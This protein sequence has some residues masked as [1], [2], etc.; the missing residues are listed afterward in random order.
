MKS[1]VSVQQRPCESSS[2]LDRVGNV[3][4]NDVQQLWLGTE[5]LLTIRT[6]TDAES[7]GEI[8]ELEVAPSELTV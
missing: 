2:A 4:V 7:D 5:G 1:V 8:E 3:L 6:T